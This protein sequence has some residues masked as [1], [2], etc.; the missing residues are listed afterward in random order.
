MH[1]TLK[2]EL[3]ESKTLITHARTQTARFL[4]YEVGVIHN[5]HLCDRTGRR[6]TNGT[7]A[8]TVPVEVTKAKCAAYMRRGK[9]VH[10]TERIFDTDFSIVA[11]YQ[12]EFRGIAEYYRLAYNRSTQF[13]WLKHV[14]EQSLTKTLARKYRLSVPKVYDRYQAMLETPN[15]PRKGLQVTVEREGK[16]P[17]VAQWGGISLKRRL[18]VVLND[19][20]KAVHNARTELVQR[21]L[22]EVCEL[23]GSTV[24]VAV[25]HVRRL[26]DLD[27]QGRSTAPAWVKKMA[28]RHR[29][30]LVVCATCHHDIH[31]GRADGSHNT[32]HGHRRAG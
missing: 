13:T 14:M 8:L 10:L 3:S 22:A 20:P 25:H 15:G 21:L 17:L 23:C 18:E 11:Q 32:K 24:G 4:G 30:T 2:L 5:D 7:V 1:D 29:K 16:R 28:A 26:K 6:A 27:Q 12:Q 31:A 19:A 9:P